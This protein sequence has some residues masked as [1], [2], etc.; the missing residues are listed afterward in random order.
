MPDFHLFPSGY[1]R[2][3]SAVNRSRTPTFQFSK[4]KAKEAPFF[5]VKTE[6]AFTQNLIQKSGR[7]F[8]G[9]VNQQ[10]GALFDLSAGAKC[11]G[12]FFI[13]GGSK[14]KYE[15]TKRS[16]PLFALDHAVERAEVPV[17]RRSKQCKGCTHVRHGFICWH[18][19][20]TCL[21]TD[22]EKIEKKRGKHK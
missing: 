7:R 19:E 8:V 3:F 14:M 18:R 17:C 6:D 12:L 21:K 9:L 2:E 4:A 5:S 13:R 11:F 22:M 15:S 1:F 20:G 10:T 16:S